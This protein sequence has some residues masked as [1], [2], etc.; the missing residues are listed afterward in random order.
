MWLSFRE[1]QVT[2]EI[3]Q[4]ADQIANS[5][6]APEKVFSHQVAPSFNPSWDPTLFAVEKSLEPNKHYQLDV[7]LY[8][9]ITYGGFFFDWLERH[10]HQSY[11]LPETHTMATLPAEELAQALQRHRVHLAFSCRLFLRNMGEI[12]SMINLSCFRITNNMAR[13]NFI[14]QLN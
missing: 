7:N 13:T 4:S 10:A 11:G 6:I 8:G 12:L 14:K 1:Y 9:G 3:E 5:C 2:H